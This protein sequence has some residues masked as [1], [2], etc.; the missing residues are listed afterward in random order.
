MKTNRTLAAL[1]AVFIFTVKPFSQA[2]GYV[3][4]DFE[5][6]ILP[7]VPVFSEVPAANAIPGWKPYVGGVAV[8]SVLYNTVT[9]GS[10]AVCLHDAGSVYAPLEGDY[11]VLLL[12]SDAIHGLQSSAIGQSG[13]IP[14]YALS[15]YFIASNPSLVVTF[16]G[17]LL[18]TT[19]V[20]TSGANLLL[21]AD[22]SAYAGMTGEL[23][24]TRPT[25]GGAAFLDAVSFSSTTIPEPTTLTLAALGSAFL[26]WRRQRKTPAPR[27]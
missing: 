12:S 15:L 1:V 3:N 27:T 16:D 7:L 18:P 21:G 19:T 4:L 14:A 5:S 13:Q 24:F 2:Q 25:G 26:M 22:I 6:P 9:L 8:S 10:A 20:G 11:S 23:L 17:N